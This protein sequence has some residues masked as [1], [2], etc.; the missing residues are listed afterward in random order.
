MRWTI[1]APAVSL[2][3]MLAAPASAA[4]SDFRLPEP[5][6]NQPE[7]E[8]QGPVAPD[9]P[10]SRRPPPTPAPAATR[11]PTPTPT[12]TP[13]IVVP[14]LTDAEPRAAP[15]ATRTPA[16]TPLPAAEAA[17]PPMVGA[18]SPVGTGQP[19]RAADAA[20]SALPAAPIAAETA[21][22]DTEGGFPWLWIVAALAALG[23]LAFAGWRVWQQRGGSRPVV[24]PPIERPRPA[25]AAARFEG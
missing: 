17:P 21:S 12:P 19:D 13:T 25:P 8:R 5:S 15:R 20:P 2:A 4:L 11:A 3:A 7:P 16:A 6:T 22:P 10:E 1:L 9:V 18:P 24:T 23:A 14:D